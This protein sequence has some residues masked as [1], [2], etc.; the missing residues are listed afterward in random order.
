MAL[1]LRAY[2]NLDE[3]S[4]LRP[5]W[6]QLLSQY[7]LATTFSTWEWLSS[8]WKCFGR[9]RQLLALALFDSNSL[10]GL[11]ALSILKERAGWFSLRVVRLMGDGSGDSDNLDMPVRPGFERPFAQAILQHLSDQRS[12]WDVC[13]LN[14]LPMD[15]LVGGCLA[16]LIGR[17]WAKFEYVSASSTVLLPETWDLYIQT[18]SSEDRKNLVR[19]ERRLQA[20]H[21]VRIYRCEDRK[22]LPLCLNALFR[23]HQGRWQSIGEAGSFSVTERR[24]FYAHLSKFL[25]TR[26]WLELWVMELD[27]QKAAVQFAFRFG[28]RVFQLQEGYDH[29]RPSDRLGFVLR[30]HVLKQLISRGVRTYDFLGGTDSYKARWGARQGH[31]RQL[32]FAPPL[33]PGASWL[34]LVNKAGRGKEWM[35]QRFPASVWNLLHRANLAANRTLD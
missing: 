13:L 17:L 24:E 34:Q 18:L 8:W 26:G 6:D 5:A 9:K 16:P 4:S 12:D 33:G 7:P 21:A 27:G 29:T 22:E 10:L 14:T 25:L 3:L 19:Y 15:S 30:G 32:H 11:A 2:R 31:Y 1:S 35:R 28:N 23:L 20:R